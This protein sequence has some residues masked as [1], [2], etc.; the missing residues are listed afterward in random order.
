VAVTSRLMPCSM[1]LLQDQ[2][3]AEVDTQLTVSAA[4][5]D[6]A[7]AQLAAVQGQTEAAQVRL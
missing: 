6:A 4:R 2:L 1:Q 3:L 7:D 5:A